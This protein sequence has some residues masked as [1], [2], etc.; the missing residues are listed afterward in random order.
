[1]PVLHHDGKL[2]N[3]SIPILK[4]VGRIYGYYPTDPYDGW[5]VD[6]LHDALND[7][8][9]ALLK[10]RQ[11]KDEA[12]KKELFLAFIS[13]T[14][15]QTLAKFEKRLTTNSSQ[16]FFVGDKLSTI[17]FHIVSSILSIAYNEHNPQAPIFKSV[18]DTVPVLKA[19]FELHVNETFKEY[20]A[21][22]PASDF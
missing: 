12:K 22:R 20:I 21:S 10:V 4:Y 5:R 13:T 14:F 15:P 2:I 1:M 9:T 6:S 18:L 3:Q 11:E 7:L 17:D 16:H 19:Y 8:I